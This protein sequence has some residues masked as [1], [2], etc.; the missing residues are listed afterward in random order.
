VGEAADVVRLATDRLNDRDVDGF[1]E[2]CSKRIR[3][4][5]V[6]EIP[7]SRLYQGPDEVRQWAEGILDIAEDYRF[8][9]W[10]KV[11]RGDAVM[12]ETSIDVTGASS[13]AELGWRFWTV[14]RVKHG[15]IV[16]HHGYSEREAA[17]ADLEGGG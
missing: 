3:F 14:W 6:P 15:R 1:V 4:Q 5:D 10:D 17:K 7:G 9:Y 13:G 2:L 11:E 16:Y 8:T 12:F